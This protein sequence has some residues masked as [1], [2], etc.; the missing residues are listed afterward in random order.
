MRA[1]FTAALLFWSC[2]AFA[3][4][5]DGHSII[6]EIAQR[7]LT[8]YASTQIANSGIVSR[9][10]TLLPSASPYYSGPSLASFAYWGHEWTTL[11]AE[12]TSWHFI[13]APLLAA[14]DLKRDCP[15]ENCIVAE[16]YRL[17]SRLLCASL[18]KER[19]DALRWIV[20]LV[21]DIHQPLN[22]VADDEAGEGIEVRLTLSARSWSRDF[23]ITKTSLHAVWDDVLIRY[24]FPSWGS[25]VDSLEQKELRDTA[26]DK[27]DGGTP[28]DWASESHKVA[29]LLWVPS[30]TLLDNEYF[31]RT[32]A[33]LNRQLVLGGLR[34]AR[35]LNEAYASRTC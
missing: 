4:G 3:W 34:L 17:K 10:Q 9:F 6:A 21:A 22:T 29:R 20:N 16:L 1:A 5:Q 28:L 8:E 18:S 25:F 19:T 7:R 14:I 13:Q 31:E 30:G 33:T 32:S 27:L 15:K 26:F 2:D 23:T 35:F 11:H 12:T 24:A